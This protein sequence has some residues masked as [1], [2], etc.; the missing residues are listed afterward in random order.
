[1]KD[2]LSATVLHNFSA[3]SLNTNMAWTLYHVRCDASDM[4]HGS[5]RMWKAFSHMPREPRAGSNHN[6]TY[7]QQ[8][9]QLEMHATRHPPPHSL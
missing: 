6:A 9:G 7:G 4:Y 2:A 1:M 3:T 5:T 8:G